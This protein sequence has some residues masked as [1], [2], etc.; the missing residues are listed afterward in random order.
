MNA[1][2]LVLAI[3]ASMLLG[4]GVPKAEAQEQLTEDSGKVLVTK[5]L[6]DVQPARLDVVV[7][8]YP[9]TPAAPLQQNY[10]KRL[11][12][13]PGETI[14]A[15]DRVLLAIPG[16]VTERITIEGGKVEITGDTI[17]I[18]GSKVEI[19]RQRRQ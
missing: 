4:A 14:V 9:A 18:E 15:K 16:L 5:F 3:S 13:L 6:Y 17:K 7:F 19:M 2:R 8:K 10:V 1:M 12:G 11:V